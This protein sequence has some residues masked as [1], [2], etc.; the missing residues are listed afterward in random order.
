V[1][2]IEFHLIF[3]LIG[4][5]YLLPREITLS[6]WAFYF[7]GRLESVAAVWM[8][9]SGEAPDIYS[10]DFPALYC[11]G[12]GAALA[13]TG[14]TIWAARRHLGR[15]LQK[16]LR[17]GPAEED[18]GGF[19]SYRTAFLGATFGIAFVL[20]WLCLAGMRLWVAALLFGLLLCYFFLFARIRAETGLGMGV[21]LFPKMLDDVMLTLVGA[22]YLHLADLTVLYAV[23]WLYHS[24]AAGSVMACELEA[25]KLADTGRL[26]GRRFGKIL[27]LITT[28]AVPL[29]FAWTLKTYYAHGFENLPIG[30]RETSMVSSQIYWSYENLVHALE[31]TTGPELS[32]IVAI[33]SGGLV[34][35][36]L[37][38]LRMRFLWFPLHPVGYLAANAWGMHINWVSFF[39]GWLA[40]LLI[41]R[42]GGLSLYRHLLPLFLGLIV[43]A[44]VHEGV[45]GMVTWATG[46][47]Q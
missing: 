47:V 29:V 26:S 15:A 13:L 32:G 19:L 46:G 16:A 37:S 9:T 11:Q 5:A 23:R 22:R 27:A 20:G 8:G 25:F 34:A 31:T 38:W 12:A 17:N 39:L 36:A 45:W 14:I 2:Q 44:M 43:G 41:N 4:I 30:Q 33:T 42:Y 1:G 28:L 6:C 7:L 21:I 24:S 18:D 10:G 40:N 3:W 35:I